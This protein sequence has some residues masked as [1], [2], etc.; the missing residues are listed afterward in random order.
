MGNITWQSQSHKR[1]DQSH[2]MVTS[3][4]VTSHGHSMWQRSQLTG[5]RTVGGKVHSHNS[6]CIYSVAESNENSIEFSLSIAEQRAVGFIPAWSL[7][8]LHP[9][10][11]RTNPLY[12]LWA[13]TEPLRPGDSQWIHEEDEVR[14]Q[15]SQVHNPQDA[16]RHNAILQ[17][18]KVSGPRVQTRRPGIPRC[19]GYQNDM[20]VSEVV[21]LQTRT[22]WNWTPSRTVSLLPQVAP[23][24]KTVAPSI[25]HGKVVYCS[26]VTSLENFL[27]ECN[28]GYTLYPWISLLE[29]T[30][31]TSYKPQ[32]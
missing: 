9:T 16:G 26:G 32:T 27:Q 19:I 28:I 31:E 2:R 21:T 13:K 12:G 4:I 3:H 7:A 24:N 22:I 29:S 25:Q 5:M 20:S 10:G 15:E 18:K 14:H 23:Q 17:L 1:Y 6:N 8:F 11:H 30:L